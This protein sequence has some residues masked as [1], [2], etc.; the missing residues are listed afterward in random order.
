MIGYLIIGCEIAF[1][2]VVTV[3]LC[4]RYIFHQKKLGNILLLLTPFIDLFL[5]L[6]TVVD[7]KNGSPASTVHGLAAVYI[8]VTIGFGHQLIKW[9]DQRFAYQFANGPKPEK[10][11]GQEHAKKERTGWLRHLL[12]YVIGTSLLL[13]IITWINNPQQTDPFI[14]LIKIW[15]IILGIDFIISFSYTVWPKKKREGH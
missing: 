5:L 6:F 1:W 2:I 14:R 8:G 7:L 9:M 12:S 4:C 13:I 11:Y 15:S 10:K 3:G